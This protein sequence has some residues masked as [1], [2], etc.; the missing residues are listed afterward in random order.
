MI[1]IF[2]FPKHPRQNIK[3][4]LFRSG[5]NIRACAFPVIAWRQAPDQADPIRP[6]IPHSPALLTM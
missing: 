3:E 1:W 5:K 6:T 2:I 4:R